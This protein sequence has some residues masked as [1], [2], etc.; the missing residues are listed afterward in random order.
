MRLRT[1]MRSSQRDRRGHSFG[2]RRERG[3]CTMP[4][5][6]GETLL[7]RAG[8]DVRSILASTQTSSKS[9]KVRCKPVHG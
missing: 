4:A 7:Q 5:H 1:P 9:L 6:A 2:P 8:T 3:L